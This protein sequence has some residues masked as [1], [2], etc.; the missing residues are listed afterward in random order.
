MGC[1]NLKAEIL[2][3]HQRLKNQRAEL[4]ELRRRFSKK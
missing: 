2:N 3:P 1:M 4:L